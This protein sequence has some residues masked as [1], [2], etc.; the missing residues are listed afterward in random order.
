M[1][2]FQGRSD[3]YPRKRMAEPVKIAAFVFWVALTVAFVGLDALG[4]WQLVA[5]LAFT[6]AVFVLLD[7]DVRRWLRG[8]P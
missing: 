3:V 5:G 7:R 6:V 2:A 1:V 8:K 4:G